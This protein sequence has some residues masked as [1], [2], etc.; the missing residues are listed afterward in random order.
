MTRVK[1]I[2]RDRFGDGFCRYDPDVFDFLPLHLWN[3]RKCFA[4]GAVQRPGRRCRA[5]KRNMGVRLKPTH[6]VI[7]IDPRTGGD[8]SFQLFCFDVGLNPDDWPCVITGS[9]GRHYYLMSPD[10]F[11]VQETFDEYPG[12]EFKSVGRQVVAAGSRHPNGEIYRWSRTNPNIRKGIPMAP[13]ALLRAIKQSERCSNVGGDGG[14]YTVEQLA[15]ALALLDVLDF[16]EESE[17]RRLM[18]A[19]HHATNGD[20]ERVFVDWSA[21]DPQFDDASGDVRTRWRSCRNKPNSITYK[22][23]NHILRKHGAGHLIP[24]SKDDFQSVARAR[25]L[26]KVRQPRVIG[27]VMS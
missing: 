12:I 18:F 13:R 17:W 20:G 6:L 4:N 21:G 9:G 16:R 10:G 19:C 14:Q 1:A 23:L 25:N 26:G 15:R 11:A 8:K 27:K 2:A 22:T 7:D 5:E 24:I 3:A